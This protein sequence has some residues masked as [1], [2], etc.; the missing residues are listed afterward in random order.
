MT[1]DRSG[2]HGTTLSQYP[3]ELWVFIVVSARQQHAAC[4]N[5]PVDISIGPQMVLFLI[6]A[7]TV[8]RLHGCMLVSLLQEVLHECGGATP[9]T[10]VFVGAMWASEYLEALSAAGL[11]DTS[12]AASTGNTA[13]FLVGRVSY[14]FGLR[15][16]CVSTDTACSSSLVA[17]HLGHNGEGTLKV[18]LFEP[19][20]PCAADLSAFAADACTDFCERTR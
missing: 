10:G 4:G 2:L 17:A 8:H 19:C 15:G 5:M 7:S 3:A 14:S 20:E 12:A 6:S 11:S 1:P 9:A 16:P 18:M 13:P